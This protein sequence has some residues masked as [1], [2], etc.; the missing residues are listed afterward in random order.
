LARQRAF[1]VSIPARAVP[2]VSLRLLCGALSARQLSGPADSRHIDGLYTGFPVKIHGDVDSWAS[3]ECPPA[4]HQVAPFEA[5]KSQP[6]GLQTQS[7]ESRPLKRPRSASLASVAGPEKR[8]FAA[9]RHEGGQVPSDSATEVA[10]QPT[11]TATSGEWVKDATGRDLSG[12]LTLINTALSGMRT[13]MSDLRTEVSGLRTEV[14]DLRTGM[15]DLR[16][17]VS[18]LRTGMTDLHTEVSDLRTGMMDLRTEVSDLRTQV[19]IVSH[20]DAELQEQIDE[21]RGGQDGFSLDLVS[22][23]EDVDA[24]L[25]AQDDLEEHICGLIDDKVRDS[26]HEA[27]DGAEVAAKCDDVT[28]RIVMGE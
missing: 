15:T 21:L 12:V 9:P 3:S 6:A 11:G 22:L 14:S 20:P 26:V 2:S 17:E 7:S 8:V 19:R 4:Y 27:L 10:A 13:E 1:T 28:F 16:T 24:C 5:P 18:D 25:A 23:H